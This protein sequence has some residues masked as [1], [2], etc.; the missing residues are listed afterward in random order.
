MQKN[1]SIPRYDEEPVGI[2]R[3]SATDRVV[4]VPFFD[5]DGKPVDESATPKPTP[6]R[7]ELPLADGAHTPPFRYGGVYFPSSARHRSL[8]D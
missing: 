1:M 6:P 2:H 5:V 8:G 4:R 3:V 7:R